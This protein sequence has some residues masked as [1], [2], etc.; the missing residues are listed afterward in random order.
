MLSSPA[1]KKQLGSRQNKRQGWFD[2]N[3]KLL[4]QLID[5]KRKAF[6]ALQNEQKLATKRK[7]YQE[8]KATVQK[9][10]R[11]PKKVWRKKAQEI[12]QLAD[13]ND[14]RGFFNAT[15][16][17]FGPSTH[18]Q[19]FLKCK[20]GSTILRSNADINAKSREHFE[21]LVNQTVLFDRNMINKFQNNPLRT[22]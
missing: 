17:I 12:Q 9:S 18:G 1:A 6:I 10:T 5:G 11:N 19:A 14:T 22:P 8:C 16:T 15:K 2:D 3:G 7:R 4:Q 13:A 21:D 20:D